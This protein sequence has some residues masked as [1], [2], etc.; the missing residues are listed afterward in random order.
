MITSAKAM[1]DSSR[2]VADILGPALF[3]LAGLAFFLPGAT[4]SDC[5]GEGITVTGWQIVTQ[6]S[7]AFPKHTASA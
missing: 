4:F 3:A 6:S 7:L 2:I 1:R 5:S